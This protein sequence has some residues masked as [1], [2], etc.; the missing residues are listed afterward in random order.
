MPTCN[1]FSKCRTK[2]KSMA[3]E[4]DP[5][6]PDAPQLQESVQIVAISLKCANLFKVYCQSFIHF[7]RPRL[8]SLA[9]IK[10]IHGKVCMEWF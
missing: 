6:P 9:E 4:P 8:R 10:E 5:L 1:T 2:F 7:R 3:K